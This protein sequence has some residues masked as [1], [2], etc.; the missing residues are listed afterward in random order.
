MNNIVIGQ[1]IDFPIDISKFESVLKTYADKN[2]LLKIELNNN[3]QSVPT[4]YINQEQD[5]PFEIVRIRSNLK[6]EYEET[7][8]R[9]T[10]L[11]LN[12]FENPLYVV[13]LIR[14]DSEW[15]LFLKCHHII[16]DGVSIDTFFTDVISLYNSSEELANL[17]SSPIT[18]E[19]YLEKDSKYFDSSKFERDRKY[20]LDKM[21]KLP[22]YVLDKGNNL[23]NY[24]TE[25]ERQV[26]NIDT[27][28]Y[29]KLID[30]AQKKNMSLFTIFMAALFLILSDEYTD[31]NVS[32]GTF[33][34]NR[35]GP[36][37]KSMGMFVSTVPILLSVDSNLSFFDLMKL[38]QTEF[39]EVSKHHQYPYNY[40]VSELR[41]RKKDFSQL[42]TIGIEYQDFKGEFNQVFTGF[43][44]N[45]I[46]LHIKNYTNLETISLWFDYRT[47]LVTKDYINELYLK[48]TKLL[49]L[50]TEEEM[51]T[52]QELIFKLKTTISNSKTSENNHDII[53]QFDSI[54]VTSQD[55]TALTYNDKNISYGELNNKSDI[56]ANYLLS[57]NIRRLDKIGIL[58]E[59]TPNYIV[60]I[61]GVLKA[62]AVY[63]PL[64]L[65]SPKERQDFI[66]KDSKI[67]IVINDSYSSSKELVEN[68]NIKGII[69]SELRA[70]LQITNPYDRQSSPDSIAYIMYTSGTTGKPKGVQISHENIMSLVK[71]TNYLDFNEDMVIL[72]AAPMI[73]DAS[74][75]EIWG[76]L[77][78][79]GR[80]VFLES[81]K[82]TP[83][84]IKEIVNREKVNVAFFT[85][86]LFNL[87][88][89]IDISTFKNLD[90]LLFGGE[91]VSYSHVKKILK[92]L[93]GSLIHVYGPTENTTF[94]TFC[95]V[96]NEFLE[97]KNIPIGKALT[98]CTTYI[99]NESF[100]PVN[101]GEVGELLVGGKGLTRG[102]VDDSLNTKE[103]FIVYKGE[104]F[105]RTGDFVKELPDGNILFI[106]RVDHQVKIRG[107]RI[108]LEEIEK[109]LLKNQNIQS[110]KVIC[111]N[112]DNKK[113]LCAFVVISE[114]L[115]EDSI[116]QYLHQSLPEYMVPQIIKIIDEMPLTIN[117]KIDV[118]AL[119]T[120]SFVEDANSIPEVN[121][122]TDDPMCEIMRSI[123]RKTLGITNVSI[124]DNFFDLG[125]DSISAIQ[126]VS[127]LRKKEFTIKVSEILKLK[128]IRR[129]RE[130]LTEK[131]TDIY[132]EPSE[133]TFPLTPIQQDYFSNKKVF[134]E[135]CCQSLLVNVVST[136]NDTNVLKKAFEQIMETHQSLRSKFI[137]KS[138]GTWAQT[139]REKFNIGDSFQWFTHKY[140]GEFSYKK[141]TDVVKSN[142][143]NSL[144]YK[145]G[146]LLRIDVIETDKN[147]HLLITIHH[148]AIDGVSWRILLD[149]LNLLLINP[150][151][152]LDK[153]SSY[154]TW[155]NYLEKYKQTDRLNIEKNYWDEICKA[156]KTSICRNNILRNEAYECEVLST[157]LKE[158]GEKKSNKSSLQNML[159][160][161]L[162]ISLRCLNCFKTECLVMLESHG[163]QELTESI[164][165]DRTIGWFTACYPIIL[166][167]ANEDQN[168]EDILEEVKKRLD[169][170]PNNGIGFSL[171][172][173][174]LDKK[175]RE[176]TFSVGEVC[177]NFLGK[178]DDDMYSELS[179]DYIQPTRFYEQEI[180]SKYNLEVNCYL[181]GDNFKIELSYN[182]NLFSNE[183]VTKF[184]EVFTFE[185]QNFFSKQ[186]STEDEFDVSNE[187]LKMISEFLNLS[188]E[189]EI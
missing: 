54:V 103:R 104:R 175:N 120:P 129:I 161:C 24:S 145:E 14:F 130:S 176:D 18:I 39:R 28:L 98:D 1:K 20:W 108:E 37:K 73:F 125:G 135:N 172:N 26:L 158:I 146:K 96:T 56:V 75:F 107:H 131:S 155:A 30:F 11:E 149:D 134:G 33:F 41:K 181:L 94:S 144:S 128:T 19:K 142:P 174:S 21:N 10:N 89:D 48:L 121:E 61:L 138:D 63:V 167:I 85:T 64:D 164:L 151:A 102:Y 109:A 168:S 123:W 188:D 143:A 4:Q 88:I 70:A 29:K 12:L 16:I 69:Q 113:N 90:Y 25:A 34:S 43:E 6:I 42:Y 84:E 87:I 82:P 60:T 22:Q 17:V 119:E 170:T 166:P 150:Q 115:T 183:Q 136:P 77:L 141:I 152:K 100:N 51:L 153:T 93:T 52:G 57:R 106:G 86:A 137:R 95:K 27:A 50:V 165:L 47:Q 67:K 49:N 58:M 163:R 140:T 111:F 76:T 92:V 139:I 8:Q 99:V 81:D 148:L 171:L 36:E 38:V 160:S 173:K 91:T 159:L 182:P 180:N 7:I 5:I 177:F 178:F 147:V 185:L 127:E 45:E 184:F 35:K 3:S 116:R 79:G 55:K 132:Y 162:S 72:Q 156:E 186:E 112:R 122:S 62:G 68:V 46:S 15:Y 187:E 97:T 71:N 124:D 40:L 133:G 83:S 114:L 31:E 53:K 126:I 23:I 154:F 32:L 118:D 110:T 169:K 105:Y 13:Y 59:R 157:S 9:L 179:I 65:N 66:I 44:A 80:L 189:G 101:K 74:T 2:E 117:G 78:N